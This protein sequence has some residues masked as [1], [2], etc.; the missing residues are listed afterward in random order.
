MRDTI[1]ADQLRGDPLP[2][3]RVMVRLTHDRQTSVGVQVDK[4]RTHHVL[5][6]VNH[7]GRFKLLRIAAMNG[8]AFVFHENGTM[9]ARAATAVDYHPI[10]DDQ[11]QHVAIPF[12]RLKPVL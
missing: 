11:I 6:R 7:P 12:A 8:H 2:N 3:L 1:N 10:F 4:T 5:R 9:K